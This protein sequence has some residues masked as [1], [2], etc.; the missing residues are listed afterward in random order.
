MNSNVLLNEN[1]KEHYGAIVLFY[2]FRSEASVLHMQMS[3]SELEGPMF[4]PDAEKLRSLTIRLQQTFGL[5]LFGID[6]IVENTTGRYAIIDINT[7]PG[8]HS[9]T[10]INS[11]Q[12][13]L[14]SKK[15]TEN[16]SN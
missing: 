7:F 9:L 13:C 11:N 10:V 12:R 2:C 15:K 3:A 14:L 6:V 5:D 8:V 16:Y 4:E 1:S